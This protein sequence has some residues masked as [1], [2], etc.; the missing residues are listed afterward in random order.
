[1]ETHIERAFREGKTIGFIYGFL[2]ATIVI[3]IFMEILWS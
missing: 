3:G 2:A 1:M